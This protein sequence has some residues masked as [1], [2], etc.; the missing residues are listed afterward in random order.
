ML[1][2]KEKSS[3]GFQYNEKQCFKIE[4]NLDMCLHSY[5]KLCAIQ[6]KMKP[7]KSEHFKF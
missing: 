3:M 4:K 1:L 7:K 5:R 6:G 2:I